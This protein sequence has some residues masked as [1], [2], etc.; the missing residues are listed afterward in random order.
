MTTLNDPE[1]PVGDGGLPEKPNLRLGIIPLCDC[2]TIVAAST[3]GFF[4]RHGL[5]VEICKE[6]AWATIRDK[7]A[8]GLL[9]GAHMLAPMPI[10]ATLG[11]GGVRCPMVTSMSL[12]LNGNA[13]TVSNSLAAEM[14]EGDSGY[15]GALSSPS[16]SAEALH[17]IVC[18]RRAENRPPITFGMVFPVSTHNYELRYW[19]AS[20]GIDPDKDVRLIVVPPPQMVEHLAQERIDGYCVG[21]P[22]NGM[23]VSLGIGRIVITKYD[24]WQNGPEKVLG[25]TRQWAQ[26]HPNT[27]RALVRALLEAAQWV[28]QSIHRSKVADMISATPYVNAPPDIVRW[29]MTGSL[30]MSIDHEPIRMP[31]F[32]VFHRYAATFPWRSHAVWLTTQMIRWRQVDADVDLSSVA[33]DVYQPAVYRAA[34]AD[35]GM[36]APTGDFKTEGTHDDAW[37]LNGTTAAIRM[38]PDHFFDGMSFNPHRPMDYLRQFIVGQAPATGRA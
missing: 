25:V 1:L 30:P 9:D 27:H 34:A 32:H 7:V 22:W 31:D 8:V 24:L 5:D 2:A 21:E 17:A 13:I 19:M 23:A 33:S 26:E 14:M 4:K 3:M 10:A 28:D 37:S 36:A 35:L 11:V 15:P 16:A 20:A 29:S 38:G 12:N 6:Q 18:R